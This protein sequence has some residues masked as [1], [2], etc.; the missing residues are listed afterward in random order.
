MN[1][2]KMVTVPVPFDRDTYEEKHNTYTQLK[3]KEDHIAVMDD[4]Y[5]TL[6][7]H[8]LSPSRK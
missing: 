6:H 2:H 1:L 4:V 8:L 3:L 5:I 7:G